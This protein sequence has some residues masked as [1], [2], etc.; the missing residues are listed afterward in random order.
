ML[1]KSFPRSLWFF[2]LIVTIICMTSNLSSNSKGPSKYTNVFMTDLSNR[3]SCK[4]LFHKI[5]FPMH[6]QKF[7]GI[8]I[9]SL[10]VSICISKL[11]L[12]IL[13]FSIMFFFFCL[14]FSIFLFLFFPEKTSILVL[15]SSTLSTSEV[16]LLHCKTST[17]RF[18]S[19][20]S[21]CTHLLGSLSLLTF[22]EARFRAIKPTYLTHCWLLHRNPCGWR[23]QQHVSSWCR[24]QWWFSRL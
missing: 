23:C 11:K 7:F 17:L 10:P 9:T 20:P 4:L 13:T 24:A 22:K 15:F 16:N 12:L 14:I 2:L 19:S 1:S 6:S 3:R 5:G 18:K 21:K 8:S